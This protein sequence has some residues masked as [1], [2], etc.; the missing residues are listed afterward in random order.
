MAISGHEHSILGPVLGGVAKG[1]CV[2][3][4]SSPGWAA[5]EAP[6]CHWW[7]RGREA[8]RESTVPSTTQ[9]GLLWGC[10]LAAAFKYVTGVFQQ[11]QSWHGV[12]KD[13]AMSLRN[14]PCGPQNCLQSA[15]WEALFCF[16][17]R[18]CFLFWGLL[19]YWVKKSLSDIL[20]SVWF[21][22][23]WCPFAAEMNGGEE[24]TQWCW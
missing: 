17:I 23:G 24:K 10:C 4:P 3:T 15:P 19:I 6:A 5:F 7:G 20:N 14:V 1:C 22:F 9:H 16:L 13:K 8:R 11:L 2:S 12:H 18:S 21:K